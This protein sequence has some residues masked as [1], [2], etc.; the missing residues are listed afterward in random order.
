[1]G[2]VSCCHEP[3]TAVHA[4]N[5]AAPKAPRSSVTK[6]NADEPARSSRQAR[7][8]ARTHAAGI[9]GPRWPDDA[10]THLKT[11]NVFL[12]PL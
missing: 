1:M 10:K 9:V 5:P 12:H 8:P 11:V 6:R 4:S 2:G 3:T 7:R